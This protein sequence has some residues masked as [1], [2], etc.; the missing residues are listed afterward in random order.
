MSENQ[1]IEVGG[2]ASFIHG[3]DRNP[4]TVTVNQ[5]GAIVTAD[6]GGG[7]SLASGAFTVG[8]QGVL[9]TTNGAGTVLVNQ[10][11]SGKFA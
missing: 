7:V 6:A 3:S 9:A 2:P 8:G 5:A 11:A 1:N 10:L 4:G